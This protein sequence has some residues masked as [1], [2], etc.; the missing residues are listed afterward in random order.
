MVLHSHLVVQATTA[1]SSLKFVIDCHSCHVTKYLKYLRT[2]DVK[3]FKKYHVQHIWFHHDL[4]LRIFDSKS[5]PYSFSMK[6]INSEYYLKIYN[7]LFN[8]TRYAVRTHAGTIH[9][10]K[11]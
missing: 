2:F 1:F 11:T 4:Q 3:M 9:K 7:I 5:D 10:S 8:I 6:C